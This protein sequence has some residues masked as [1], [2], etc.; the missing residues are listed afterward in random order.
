[1]KYRALPR[2]FRNSSDWEGEDMVRESDWMTLFK[3]RPESVDETVTK[4]L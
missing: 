4:Y 3:A 1:V 2:V